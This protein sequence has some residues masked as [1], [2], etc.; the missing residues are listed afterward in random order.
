[1]NN[2]NNSI[3]ISEVDVI[4]F[5]GSKPLSLPK[6]IRF[7]ELK[8]QLKQRPFNQVIDQS[9]MNEGV[10]CEILQPGSKAWKKGK[11]KIKFEFIPDDIEHFSDL[12]EFRNED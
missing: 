5:S 6:T 7:I 3:Q 1:M 12:D 11:I 2:Q 4:S 8:E 10:E 9:L